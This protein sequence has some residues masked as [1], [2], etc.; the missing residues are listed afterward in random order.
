[1][2][3]DHRGTV[4]T[5]YP[6]HTTVRREAARGERGL[7]V[8]AAKCSQLTAF[9]SWLTAFSSQLTAFS[10]RLTAFSSGL[11]AVSGWLTVSSYVMFDSG[12]WLG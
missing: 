4:F 10:S 3:T 7:K 6:N 11:T 12:F 2:L 9:R 1:M 8:C 5:K